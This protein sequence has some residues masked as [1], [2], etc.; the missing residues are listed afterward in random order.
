MTQADSYD[1]L[2][3]KI[4]TFIRKY[5][6]NNLLRGLIFL[7]AGLFSLYLIVTVTEY[8]GNFNML[9]RSVLFYIFIAVNAGLVIWL[10]IPSLLAW[11]KV[12][13]T[14]SHDEAARIIGRHFS[15]VN[16]KLLNTLQLK[17]QAF[18]DPRQQELIAAGIDQKIKELKPVSFPS[19]INLKQNTRYLKW[20]IIPVSIICIIALT[21]PSI[22]TE[23]TKRL[24]RHNEYFAPAAPYQFIVL[25]QSLTA[26]QGDDMP[27]A[28]KLEGNKLPSDVYIETGGNTFKLTKESVTRFAHVFKNMQQNVTFRL[29]ANG[30]TSAPYLI[31]VNHKPTVINFDVELNYPAY[32]H[33]QPEKL[34]NAG[35]LTIPAGT[36]VKWQVHTQYAS[37]LAFTLNGREHLLNNDNN[38]FTYSEKVYKNTDYKLIPS[39]TVVNR[40]D[41]SA[42]R[43]N[44]INDELPAILVE[45]KQDSISSKALY[46]NGTIQDDHGF[47][48]LTFH[49]R[50]GKP[51][52]KQRLYTK[53]VKADLSQTQASFFHFWDLTE[54]GAN[55][56]EQVTYFFEVADNDGVTGPKKSRSPERTLNIPDAKQLNEQLDKGTKAVQDKTESAVK[57]A[58]QIEKE[59]QKLNQL[60]LNKNNL[61]FDEKKQV[62]ELLQKK[63]EL[64]E[65][66]KDI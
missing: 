22:L 57:L 17:Q 21:A 25:N 14:L 24:I 18:N 1:S 66:I 37:Q 11:L 6:F 65:L 30:Y 50:I 26:V 64:N 3:D 33:K 34:Q 5:Y 20:V 49:Y 36:V 8:F 40:S 27:L 10:V 2:I 43:I 13:K 47:S 55:P 28:I 31:K 58:A 42:Y 29:T 16:D 46:F 23:S 4:N 35:D 48:A 32:L 63:M 7:G 61:S 53:T 38:L 39:N 41:S 62:E 56:G 52:Q 59:S 44:V 15:H 12:G 9:L 60:L 45:E 51:G 19:A 54:Q